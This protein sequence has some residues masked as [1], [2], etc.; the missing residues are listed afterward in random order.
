[1]NA[2][3]SSYYFFLFQALCLKQIFLS[4]F[5]CQWFSF[6]FCFCHVFSKYFLFPFFQFLLLLWLLLLLLR[7]QN[8]YF[9]LVK[10]SN[11]NNDNI[12]ATCRCSGQ[13]RT[14]TFRHSLPKSQIF[15]HTRRFFNFPR[16]VCWL[17]LFSG[18]I[19][20]LG[21]IE[22]IGKIELEIGFEL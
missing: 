15:S 16:A 8:K 17:F 18:I 3:F 20:A 19:F 13:T 6:L 2:T 11:P 4:L 14:F 9:K 7:I 10:L 21:E 1:M 22:A 5:C 12:V